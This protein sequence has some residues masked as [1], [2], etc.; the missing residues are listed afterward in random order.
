MAERGHAPE[1]VWEGGERFAPDQAQ[2][3]GCCG[4]GAPKEFGWQR[5]Q[6]E[7]AMQYKAAEQR[8]LGKTLW[9]GFQLEGPPDRAQEQPDSSLIL[10]TIKSICPC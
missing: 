9:E 2:G 10:P 3:G 4:R 6:H 1:G 5:S 8:E 7:A